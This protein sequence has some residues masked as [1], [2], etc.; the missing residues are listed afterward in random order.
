MS[1]NQITRAESYLSRTIA[2]CAGAAASYVRDGTTIAVTV[3]FGR[4]EMEVRTQDG[5]TM[6]AN[7]RTGIIQSSELGSV[8]PRAGDRVVDGT[9]RWI[10]GLPGMAASFE[11]VGTTKAMVRVYLRKDDAEYP[12]G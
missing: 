3:V 8:I 6:V 11:Y 10:V 4:R 2:S 1:D 12:A 7:V 9:E 5:A